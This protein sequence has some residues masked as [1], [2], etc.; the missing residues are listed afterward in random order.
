MDKE[1]FINAFVNDLLGLGVCPGDVL[2]VHSSLKPFGYVPGGTSTVVKG[3][4]QTLGNRGTLLMPALSWE[5]VT[6]KNPIFNIHITPSCVG[7]IAETFRLMPETLRSFHPT[8]S[9][10]GMGKFASELIINH[11][12]D[13]TPCGDNS[14]FRLLPKYGGKI[15]MLACDLIFNTS[16]HAIE[17]VIEPPYLFGKPITYTLWDGSNK[18]QLKEYTPHNFMGWQ[19]R[20]DRLIH[21]LTEPG[22]R[23]SLIMKTRSHLID[24]EALWGASI[25]TLRKNPLYFVEKI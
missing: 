12:K 25:P 19:Q 11:H 8:H 2:L 16:M 24:A 21:I 10:C 20:Y 4:L 13:H 15:L 1:C 17:E 23:S 22:L 7:L 6:P 3:L 9:V 18:C 14:P 5:T